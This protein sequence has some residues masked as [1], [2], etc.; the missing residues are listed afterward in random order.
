MDGQGYAKFVLERGLRG[1]E[2]VIQAAH[3]EI[4]EAGAGGGGGRGGAALQESTEGTVLFAAGTLYPT[5]ADV[6]L[7][8]QV[9]KFVWSC[10]YARV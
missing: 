4:G 6:F 2:T 1:L 3:A 10:V 8:P 9:R 5:L 7:V